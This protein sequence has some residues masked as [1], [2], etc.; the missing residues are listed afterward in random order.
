MGVLKIFT[1]SERFYSVAVDEH[2]GEPLMIV[3][4]TGLG[5]RDLVF[6]LTN[7]D[8]EE[9]KKD[10]NSLADLADRLAIDKGE[11]FY[12]DRLVVV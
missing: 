8:F 3:T 5:W 9:F 7:D 10:N 4:I 2:S 6:R 12:R 11:R 1:D